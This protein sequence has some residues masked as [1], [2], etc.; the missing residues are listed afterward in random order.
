M[1][2]RTNLITGNKMQ[3]QFNTVSS[4]VNSQSEKINNLFIGDRAFD[5]QI[6][7]LGKSHGVYIDIYKE[8]RANLGK[9]YD[10]V[11]ACIELTRR[12]GW[13]F[14]YSNTE[15]IDHTLNQFSDRTLKRRKVEAKDCVT[16]DH[17]AKNRSFYYL[18][19][20]WFDGFINGIFNKL[21]IQQGQIGPSHIISNDPTPVL[22]HIFINN[23]DLKIIEEYENLERGPKSPIIAIEKPLSQEQ[24]TR[25]IEKHIPEPQLKSQVT[26]FVENFDRD[27]YKSSRHALNVAFKLINTGRW[28]DP[29]GWR[30]AQCL[31]IEEAAKRDKEQFTWDCVGNPIYNM[32]KT[33]I[34][35]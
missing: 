4:H 18:N 12:F 24:I 35:K 26:W 3:S 8:L 25:R 16:V 17:G 14:H 7:E 34:R 27:K 33:K 22:D 31:A 32:L 13:G 11:A 2:H 5:R 28:S 23:I 19:K 15:F 9:K 1:L 20:T 21:G 29:K 10:Y 30:A 6:A